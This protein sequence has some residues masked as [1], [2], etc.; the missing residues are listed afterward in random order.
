[1]FPNCVGLAA[2]FDKD[3]VAVHPL[4]LAGFGF[5][6][7]GS[8]TPQPQSGNPSPR[9]FRLDEDKGVINRYG[10]NSAGAEAARENLERYRD[11]VAKSGKPAAG[12]LGVNLGKNKLSES[13]EGDYIHGLSVFWRLADY[14]VVNVSSPN[15][16][17]LRGLQSAAPLR[18]LLGRCV[19]SLDRL[20]E[21]AESGGGKR[22]PLLVKVAPDLTDEELMDVC[23]VAMEV[24][25]DGI[26]V[27]NTTVQR[28]ETLTSANKG[29]V[30]G[31]SGRPV[32]EMSTKMIAKVYKLTEGKLTII[33]V[34]GVENG[35]DA[36]DKIRA[37][38]TA[39]QVYSMLSFKG[40]GMVRTVK[41]ELRELLAK[42]GY[43]S[44][45]AAV[46]ADHRERGKGK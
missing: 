43:T 17:G 7:I 22:P 2:G 10:F 40:L 39:V 33:G 28:P 1:M 46:G 19:S 32:K 37:G 38:A 24:G 6:E 4:L 25:V 44:V 3:G 27:A 13:A 15:T 23:K 20:C 30:G 31:L 21:A 18:S 5:V 9:V 34:G 29:E 35:K 45:S 11:A 14:V 41:D 36:Y 8:V 42:D 26:V 16:P 12:L